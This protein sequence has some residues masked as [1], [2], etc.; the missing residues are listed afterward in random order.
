VIWQH[1]ADATREALRRAGLVSPDHPVWSHRPYKVFL[2]LRPEV[3][4]RI[5]YVEE[6]PLKEGLQRQ[7]WE[8]V[9]PCPYLEER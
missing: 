3:C 2:Y 9:K 4:G 5:E 1:V 6:N 8:F 7:N